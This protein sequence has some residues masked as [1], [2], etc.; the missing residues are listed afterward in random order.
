VTSFDNYSV[1]LK[2]N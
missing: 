1:D 2:E